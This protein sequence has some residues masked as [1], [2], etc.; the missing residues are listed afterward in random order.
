VKR[1]PFLGVKRS[2]RAVEDPL[3]YSAEGKS[4]WS[5]TSAPSICLRGMLWGDIY[6]YMQIYTVSCLRRLIII[7]II[8]IITTTT[9]AT[10][11]HVTY[12]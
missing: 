3:P 12:T 5:Y 2:G 4:R 9:T 1:G 11:S 10:A 8:I 6:L 7:I